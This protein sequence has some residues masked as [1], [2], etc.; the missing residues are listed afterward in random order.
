MFWEGISLLFV[1]VFVI[2]SAYFITKKIASLGFRRMQ[3]KN[4][5]IIETLQ[6]GMNQMI[7]LVK[8]GEKTVIIGVSKDRMTYLSEVDDNLIDWAVYKTS[9]DTPTFEDY[10]KKVMPKKK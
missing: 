3:G 2:G 8:V 1:F 6:L 4:M 7:C 5:K 10:F 9:D